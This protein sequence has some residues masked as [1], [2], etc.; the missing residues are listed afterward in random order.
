[1]KVRASWGRNGNL[2][3]VYAYDNIATTSYLYM[4][5]ISSANQDYYFGNG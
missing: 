5:T 4:A 2:P 1:L 3:A